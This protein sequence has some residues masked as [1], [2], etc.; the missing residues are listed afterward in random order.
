MTQLELWPEKKRTSILVGLLEDLEA[1][2]VDEAEAT[3]QLLR[4]G[5]TEGLVEQLVNLA[6]PRP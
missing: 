3:G 2:R 4:M 1:G 6:R 5:Y